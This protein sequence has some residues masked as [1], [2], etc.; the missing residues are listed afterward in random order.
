MVQVAAVAL[1]I[2]E[3]YDR[4]CAPAAEEQAASACAAGHP[5]GA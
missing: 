5:G 2:I 1:Q 4:H 3:Y